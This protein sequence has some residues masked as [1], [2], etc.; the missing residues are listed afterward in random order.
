MIGP[1]LAVA[2]DRR[3]LQVHTFTRNAGWRE[4]SLVEPVGAGPEAG[5]C[6]PVP[7]QSAYSSL[8][9]MSRSVAGESGLIDGTTLANIQARFARATP[10]AASVSRKV[11]GV[12][13][14][15]ARRLCCSPPPSLGVQRSGRP[16]G[17]IP[18]A[19][20]SWRG[21]GRSAGW[22]RR[23]EGPIAAGRS[24]RL[25]RSRP[26]Q[27][28]GERAQSRTPSGGNAL[29]CGPRAMERSSA[30]R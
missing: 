16:Y 18:V 29:A 8:S 5:C 10:W 12:A 22:P 4:T 11:P 28:R 14:D 21:F 1:P 30:R 2:L 25:Q 27:A 23:R 19:V 20:M 26:P 24:G 13:R 6:R 15:V 17:A 9:A 7:F 3:P